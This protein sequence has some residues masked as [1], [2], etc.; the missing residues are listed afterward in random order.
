MGKP[1]Q[2]QQPNNKHT[3]QIPAQRP[4]RIHNLPRNNPRHRKKTQPKLLE[5]NNQ[6]IPRLQKQRER[7]TDVLV[8][9]TKTHKTVN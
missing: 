3:R 7:P 4:N 2:K 9:N 6:K 5:H 8:H 1:Q